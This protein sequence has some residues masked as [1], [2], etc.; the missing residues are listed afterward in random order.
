MV[1][2]EG[3]PELVIVGGDS[4]E[5]R[6]KG[7]YEFLEI[8]Y[9][10]FREFTW[11]LVVNCTTARLKLSLVSVLP[12]APCCGHYG[13]HGHEVQV[14]IRSGTRMSESELFTAME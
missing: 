12:I 2:P 10:M 1:R 5:K 4:L 8:V 11:F 14:E 13:A 7:K 6:V 3:L 9:N